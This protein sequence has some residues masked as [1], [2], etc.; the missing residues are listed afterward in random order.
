MRAKQSD[1]KDEGKGKSKVW[2]WQDKPP[3]R[4]ERGRIWWCCLEDLSFL[5]IH[6]AGIYHH[7]GSST[8]V[9]DFFISSYTPSLSALIDTRNRPLP[10]PESIK[11]LAAAQPN[12]DSIEKLKWKP[13]P[14]T[15][16]ELEEIARIVP[17]QNLLYLNGQDQL[18]FMGEHTTVK[19]VLDVLPEASI[20][21]LACHGE[22]D[23][24]NPLKSG[25]I[26][27]NGER[28]T[29]QELI[30]QRT[31]NAYM[32]VLSACHTASNDAVQPEESM[33]LTRTAI[34]LGFS[35]I[36]G[37]KWPMADADGPALAKA[38]YSALFAA[39]N[40][41]LDVDDASTTIGPAKP[42]PRNPLESF[43]LAKVLDD[44]VYGLRKRGVPATRWATFVHVGI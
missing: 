1:N 2:H 36:V 7:D 28:L 6:A 35:T 32:A 3:P 21:H 24:Y 10:Q 30:K 15:K 43:C 39:S 4:H 44:F 5:P 31:P 13:L 40:T 11:V 22:Q 29:I 27:K 12:A 17:K 8:C 20:L 26:L 37:T 34:F 38:I 14:S 9:S 16:K 23:R 42:H 19:N 25:F 33:N 18:D 41:N